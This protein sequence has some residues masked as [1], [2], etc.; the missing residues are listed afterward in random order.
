MKSMV[1]FA[2]LDTLYVYAKFPCTKTHK[3]LAI[4]L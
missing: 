3:V 2:L 4:F 1:P